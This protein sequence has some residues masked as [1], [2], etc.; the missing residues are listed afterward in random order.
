[1]EHP[2]YHLRQ[3]RF[4]YPIRAVKSLST[5]GIWTCKL[6]TEWYSRNVHI[7]RNTPEVAKVAA[8]GSN[9]LRLYLRSDSFILSFFSV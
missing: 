2:N 7:L 8:Q 6:W 5:E 9:S 1:M 3:E 4:S